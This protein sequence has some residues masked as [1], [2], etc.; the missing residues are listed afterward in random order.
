MQWA[1]TTRMNPRPLAVLPMYVDLVVATLLLGAAAAAASQSNADRARAIVN[2][3]TP[4]QLLGQMN[5]INSD[6]IALWDQDQ[7]W[8]TA[9]IEAFANRG[10]GSY[11]NTPGFPRKGNQLVA[12]VAHWRQAIQELHDAQINITGIPI[13]YGIDS[14]HGAQMVDQAVLFPHNINGGATF[15]PALVYDYGKYMARDT[16]AAGIPWIFNP[17]LEVTRH[18][19]W[20]RLY[21]TYGE[22]PTVVAAMA[23]AV[24]D[25]IQSQQVAACF[26]HF[27]GYSDPA[28]GMDRDPVVLSDYEVLNYFM[29]PFKAA[30]DA[31]VM[32]GM[33][34]YIALNGVPLAANAR[35]HQGL[36]RHDLNFQGAMVT[37]WGEIYLLNDVHNVVK[38]DQDAVE[39]S[40]N[41]ATYDIAMVPYDMTFAEYGST[42]LGQQKIQLARLKQSVERI[43]K[44]KLD[45]GLFDNPV[46]G[47]DVADQVGDAAS[48]AA[49][50][51]MAQESIVLLKNANNV[52]PLKP[53][54][55]VF[56]TGPSADDIGMLC[57][58]WTYYWQGMSGGQDIFP[59]GQTAKQAIE[60]T[61]TGSHTFYQGVEMDGTFQDINKAKQLAQQHTYTIVVLGE[62]AYAEL[63]G[64]WDPAELPDGL[65]SYVQALAATNTKI[66]LVLAEGRPRLLNGIADLA[67][68]VLWAGLPCE[69]GGDAIANVLFGKVNPSGKLPYVYP[70]SNDDINLATPY[71]FRTRDRCVKM[72]TND[73]CPAEWQYGEGL[74]YTQFTYSKM[75]LSSEAFSSPTDKLTVSVTIKNTGAVAGK[76]VVMLFV[77]P[78]A[79]RQSAE[80]KLLKKFTKIELAPNQ[81]KTVSFDL[82]AADWGYYTDN[83]GQGLQKSADA[84][85]YTFFF[86][87]GTDCS[88]ASELCRSFQYGDVRPLTGALVSVA[89]KQAMD[90][91]TDDQ[92]G[93]V[94][95]IG[96][97]SWSID[98]RTKLLTATNG[99]CLD[100]YEPQNWG[101]VHL[102]ACSSDNANQKWLYDASTKQLRHETHTGFCLDVGGP[103]LWECLPTTNKDVKNQQ[104]QVVG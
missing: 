33:G 99:L 86:K 75:Q 58:G 13:L 100:A 96:A 37:D 68:A 77:T 92:V 15:N 67:S 57:G 73:A 11:L 31:G 87:A 45:L 36:L 22:D 8:N 1:M 6:R 63:E 101:A 47:A 95:A 12:G 64:N 42:L 90:S 32:T 82:T 10:V 4:D 16:K 65:I 26:K 102:W 14:I 43:I 59:H 40:L 52:L 103:W 19:H 78:P 5:Q 88:T 79:T 66:I 29:P 30:I 23:K 46:P 35:M 62:R 54:A 98:P 94:E 91:T 71:Y 3:M 18:K 25:G 51:T 34:T 28:F 21:E 27:I 60:A 2:A 53:S 84:G 50:L 17:V 56:I 70:K 48:E 76:E 39:L 7:I 55:S 85:A 80:T 83:I 49:A 81:A 41:T 24:V 72:G 93:M 38:S 104:W 44:L 9:A 74:S 97:G 69:M 89:T 61:L 20:P